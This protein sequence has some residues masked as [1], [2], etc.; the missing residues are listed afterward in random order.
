[1][2]EQV[3]RLAHH[4]TRG[5]VW[6]KS[7]VYC[8]RAADKGMARSAYRDAV[9]HLEQT[10]TALAHLPQTREVQERA[11]DLRFELRS[12]H[13]ALGE[14]ERSF[15]HLQEAER[16]ATSLG[17]ERRGGWVACYMCNHLSV[18]AGDQRRAAEAGERALAVASAHE[19]LA[20]SV[21]TRHYLG[22]LHY[23]QGDYSRAINM[24]AETMTDIGEE[25]MAES[26][27]LPGSAAVGLLNWLAMALTETGRFGE[28][29]ARAE[30]MLR[31]TEALAQ[32]YSSLHAHYGAGFAYLRKGDLESAVRSLEHSLDWARIAESPNWQCTSAALL[33][34]A[35]G[36]TGQ[37]SEALAALDR[38][39]ALLPASANP[40]RSASYAA[41]G[42]TCLLIG[43]IDDAARC[44]KQSVQAGQ[45]AEERGQLAWALRL[46]GEIAV[47]EEPPD[48]EQAEARYRESLA[49]AE[50]LGMRPLE[51]H[52]RLGLGKLH[53]RTGRLD[54]AHAEL[55]TAVAMLREMGMTF[56]LPEAEREL[57]EAND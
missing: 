2:V 12:A 36:L 28:A 44:A 48:Y 26:F 51:A 38:S 15:E 52:C 23:I 41:Y 27:G 21:L 3:E 31:I 20:L 53:R 50:E 24:L 54:E 45:A 17:D 4:A 1:L 25:H 30:Q 47:S 14:R 8:H 34:L 19:D 49:L 55:Q 6:D 22:R 35:Y 11:I 9:N 40:S 56:W 29:N 7:A 16:L 39:V 33:G 5:E 10:L 37:T 43:R 32:P 13:F 46:L 18:V 42:E 57:A